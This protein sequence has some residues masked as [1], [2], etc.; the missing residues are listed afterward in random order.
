MIESDA[1][2]TKLVVG[3]FF[4]YKLLKL[5]SSMK[6]LKSNGYIFTINFNF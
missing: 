6:I 3:I 5:L 1:V 2:R 4:E